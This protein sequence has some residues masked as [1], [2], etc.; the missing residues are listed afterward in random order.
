MI[1]QC[2]VKVYDGAVGY[3]MGLHYTRAGAAELM[4]RFRDTRAL[5]VDMRCYPREFMVFDFIGQYFI[6]SRVN[7]VTWCVS[8][9]S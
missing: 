8:E 7:H 9:T 2:E 1:E 6:R 3:M 5:I 4:E